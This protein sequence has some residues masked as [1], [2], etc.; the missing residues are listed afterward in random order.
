VAG[1]SQEEENLA[2][3]GPKKKG[4]T[5]QL[6]QG[7]RASWRTRGLV[8]GGQLVA[9]R[10]SCELLRNS[11]VA[12]GFR[13][14]PARRRSRRRIGRPAGL[15]GKKPNSPRRWSSICGGLL[16]IRAPDYDDQRHCHLRDPRAHDAYRIARA[17][18]VDPLI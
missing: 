15:K 8:A 5:V 11:R 10:G 3:A 17:L 7:G 2:H 13:L 16:D 14:G 4:G 9:A 12:R 6:N 18:S 1:S